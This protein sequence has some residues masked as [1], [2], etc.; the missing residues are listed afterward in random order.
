M[1]TINKQMQN[2]ASI[3]ENM[4]LH[5]LEL[6]EQKQEELDNTF[7]IFKKK[8]A[9]LERELQD[10][11]DT[12]DRHYN[13]FITACKELEDIHKEPKERSVKNGTKKTKPQT[14]K[15]TKNR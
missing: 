9:N 10:L 1:Y 14:T 8:R 13:N 3:E 5:Y 15:T 7:K 12:A 4:Y 2:I 6:A 11:K